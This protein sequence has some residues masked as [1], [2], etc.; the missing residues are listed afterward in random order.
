MRPKLR[1]A[2]SFLGS[3]QV[4]NGASHKQ[5]GLVLQ[6]ILSPECRRSRVIMAQ[7]DISEAVEEGAQ[8]ELV[9]L[10]TAVS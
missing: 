5:L 8:P 10:K 7:A 6:E 1:G 3:S 9:T 2:T 4:V